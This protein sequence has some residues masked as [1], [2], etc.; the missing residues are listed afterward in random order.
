MKFYHPAIKWENSDERKSFLSYLQSTLSLVFSIKKFFASQKSKCIQ[1]FSHKQKF[2]EIFNKKIDE[3][4]FLKNL[5]PQR[6]SF[7][8]KN[9][10]I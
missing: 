10:L 1:K 5:Q 6:L 8:F 9:V 3:K 4:I 2:T 7:C